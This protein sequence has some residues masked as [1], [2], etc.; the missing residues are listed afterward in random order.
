VSYTGTG[1]AATVGHGLGAAPSMV[2]V[3]NRN[4]A[5]SWLVWH[6]AISPASNYYL[7][8]DSTAA[9]TDAYNMWN[10][11]SPTS[12]VF[13][14]GTD[15]AVNNN[16]QNLIAY[17][18]S[19]IAGYSKFGSYTGNGSA[20]G[21][22]VTL[23]FKPAFVMVKNATDL[24]A[25]GESWY[26]Y[27]N[28]RDTVNPTYHKL[29]P[30]TS[31]AE[32]TSTVNNILEL[33]DTGFVVKSSNA[34]LNYNGDTY[35]YM[36][37]ADTRDLAFWRDQSGNGND[38]QPTNLNYQDTVFDS[39]T[40]NYATWNPLDQVSTT[41]TNG[42]L[43][44][45]LAAGDTPAIRA[46]IGV[47]SGKYYWEVLYSAGTNNAPHIGVADALAAIS[48]TK[49]TGANSWNYYGV[50]GN[51]WN[52]GSGSAYGASYTTG[53]VIGVALD[54]DA[55]TLTFYKNN[56][57][58]GTAFT[59]LTG[60]TLTANLGNG[61]G[62][63]TQTFI[64]NFGQSGFTYTPPAG[65][66]A[67]CTANLP[68]PSISPLYG[69]SPQDHFNTVLWTGDGG[70]T[71]DITGVGF[72]PDFVWAKRRSAADGHGLF[73]AVRGTNL[74]L[75]SNTTGAETTFG[76]SYG[77]LSFDADGYRMGNGSAVNFAGSTYVG[78]NWKA[79]NATAVSN[80]EGTI[81]SQVSA[82]P[83]AGFSVV[84]Y[85]GTGT[86]GTIGHG[87]GA[88]VVFRIAKPR[89]AV[90][91]WVCYHQSLGTGKVMV[92]NGTNAVQ[93]LANYWDTTPTSTVMQTGNSSDV[94]ANGTTYVNYCFNSV[95]GYSKFGSYTGNGSADG[96]FVY[97]GFRPKFVMY[98][99][100]DTTGQWNIVDTAR[101]TYNQ[102]DTLLRANLSIA[103]E[104]NAV[105]AQ[106][107]TSNGWKIRSTNVDINVNGG[108][109]IY[110]AFAEN[111]FKYS[112]AR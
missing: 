98:K 9:K 108:T 4:N 63:G 27:D 73:D 79:S 26:V 41:V 39:P 34:G 36:A 23:G 24:G 97:L 105:Y 80:T 46:T 102:L 11:T 90:G 101:N 53:D 7:L 112:V 31:D 76:G 49:G 58:Q 84:T 99:R 55:G 89:S 56:T 12:T 2:I 19:E 88:P 51:K 59:G 109:Y 83:T 29:N 20:S 111:P 77:L 92:L 69:A 38:W 21:P 110:M 66:L 64:A 100:T 47:S 54:M 106:D 70:A 3:K 22:T 42:N 45:V 68:E 13:S 72:K 33:T 1:A 25:S 103:D 104:I 40:N 15:G 85:T 74:W 14:L 32:S 107:F 93:T 35:I 81:T 82:N 67:L 61:T 30:N 95:E 18:F 44:A 78:W 5:T 10:A 71:I 60:K 75:Q 17:C 57:S 96:P 50:N 43:Q 94:N 48:T 52:N 91:A 86:A 8:L 87:L 16:A 37:F 28:T 6:T 62:G 65:F